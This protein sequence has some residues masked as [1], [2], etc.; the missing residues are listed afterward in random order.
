M[1]KRKPPQPSVSS[2]AFRTSA[3]ARPTSETAHV[4]RL[5]LLGW[6]L[7]A[8]YEETKVP[9]KTLYRWQ[10]NLKLYGSV[11]P[12]QRRAW[13]RRKVLTN[14]DENALFEHLLLAGWMYL[15]EMQ[16]WILE[17]RDVT[18]SVSTIS[19]M[20]KRRWNRKMIRRIA[21]ARSEEL[22]KLYLNAVSQHPAESLVFLDETIFNE[23]TGWRSRGY[24]P[25]GLEARY[26]AA[27]QGG[28]STYSVLAATTADGWLPCTSIKKGYWNT[29]LFLQWIT[30]DLLPNLY[31]VY[32]QTPKVII[33]DNASFHTDER[34]SSAIEQQGHTIEYLPPYSPDFN[35]IELSFSVLKAYVRR[36]YIHER[37]NFSNFGQ[38][39]LA[40]IQRSRCDRFARAQYRHAA[41]GRYI[42]FHEWES[43]RDALHS[44]EEEESSDDL[45]DIE[46][47]LGGYLED[48][49]MM[50]T[51]GD[52]PTFR[53]LE[54]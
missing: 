23:R 12:P 4:V 13:G 52:L 26:Q 1:P 51:A 49:W 24:A 31:E 15:D 11:R 50:L 48:E 37:E 40:A 33:M 35:P 8:I 3:R 7:A 20:L 6:K 36:W 21:N 14:A 39:L 18:V 22:R 25:I 5:L 53:L 19:R 30:N 38:F 34:I 43:F 42:K 10:Q 29:E 28:G 2:I 32:G 16:Q 44:Y 47:K 9:I 17:E 45:Q 27:R 46:R 54:L 41:R